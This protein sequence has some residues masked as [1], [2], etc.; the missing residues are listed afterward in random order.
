LSFLF[1]RV[2]CGCGIRY[3][4]SAHSCFL[5][6]RITCVDVVIVTHVY[7]HLYATTYVCMY[8]NMY[9]HTCVC[10][11][12]SLY[13]CRAIQFQRSNSPQTLNVGNSKTR[14]S[15]S[16]TA[17]RAKNSV[18]LHPR[19]DAS[20]LVIKATFTLASVTKGFAWRKFSSD[21]YCV[22]PLSFDAITSEQHVRRMLLVTVW[23]TWDR[24]VTSNVEQ[25]RLCEPTN[26]ASIVGSSFETSIECSKYV[27]MLFFCKKTRPV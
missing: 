18:R 8:V 21:A 23:I 5:R 20:I 7:I 19:S 27:S 4:E 1:S 10:R 11:H 9:V 16:L 3:V 12:T 6:F 22:Y 14:L 17:T 15:F 25:H 26:H 13:R 24:V 2:Q